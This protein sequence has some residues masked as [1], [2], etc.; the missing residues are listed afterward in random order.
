MP[1]PPANH[2]GVIVDLAKLR[3][4][5]QARMGAHQAKGREPLI[6]YLN[7]MVKPPGG[8]T[9]QQRAE[10]ISAVCLVALELGHREFVLENPPE[11]EI[12]D[13]L[14]S[15]AR[16][17]CGTD[18]DV[19]LISIL[20]TVPF[21][22]GGR[23][24]RRPGEL[25]RIDFSDGEKA[26]CKDR[27]VGQEEV[28]YSL[29]KEAGLPTCKT[30]RSGEW[31]VIEGAKGRSL[32]DHFFLPLGDSR[33]GGEFFTQL[34]A[35]SA[36]DHIFGMLDRNEGGLIFDKDNPLSVIDHEYLLVF[37]PLPLQSKN[38]LTDRLYL[39][40]LGLEERLLRDDSAMRDHMEGAVS[41]FDNVGTNLGNVMAIVSAH[42]KENPDL[43]LATGYVDIRQDALNSI[44]ER[45]A[46]GVDGFYRSIQEGM[47]HIRSLGM[48]QCP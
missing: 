46:M 21:T 19:D 22:E 1:G 13:G 14:V 27:N 35:V 16:R 24:Y 20:S 18:A 17:V 15:A 43:A 23:L 4:D 45:I 6:D 41:V 11:V 33:L 8:L 44:V 36:F 42:V 32:A 29:L 2:R 12:R 7:K 30:E 5:E 28:G 39:G 38:L 10:T 48:F 37:C 3:M 31:L 34:I 25:F 40:T 26:Y 9:P 47:A